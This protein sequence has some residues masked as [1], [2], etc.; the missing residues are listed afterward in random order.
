MKPE[1]SDPLVFLLRKAAS[2]IHSLGTQRTGD[3]PDGKHACPGDFHICFEQNPRGRELLNDCFR[4][5]R[6]SCVWFGF[7]SMTS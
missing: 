7:V 3:F 6:R 2:G 4:V 1:K 5:P